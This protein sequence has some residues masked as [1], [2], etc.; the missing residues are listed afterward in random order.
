MSRQA[1]VAFLE[2]AETDEEFAADVESVKG[3]QDAVLDKV[4]AA[5]FDASPDEIYEA[6][7][8]RY[9]I[10]LTPEQLDAIAAGS[11]DAGLIAGAVVGGVVGTA[12]VVAV[13]AA[14][15]A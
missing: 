14:F 15:A 13:C 4:H 11:D 5:G 6:F 3:N 1:A 10:E 8:D 12:A 7:T 9:G 2:R